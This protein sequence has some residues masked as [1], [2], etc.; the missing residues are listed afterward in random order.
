MGPNSAPC[1][2]AGPVL[3]C[4]QSWRSKGDTPLWTCRHHRLLLFGGDGEH[5]TAN[6]SLLREIGTADYVLYHAAF[7]EQSGNKCCN[8]AITLIE[9]PAGASMSVMTIYRQ[10]SVGV[11][12][13]NQ[14]GS[15][16]AAADSSRP[17]TG[18]Q[19]I[20]TANNLDPSRTTTS[21]QLVPSG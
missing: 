1:T 17:L 8:R 11:Q 19:L 9:C 5:S 12:F 21:Y 14:P 6:Q 13:E 15:R 10:L 18:Y 3:P 7:E 2:I 4:G 20:E 16:R